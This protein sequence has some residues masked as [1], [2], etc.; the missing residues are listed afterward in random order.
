MRIEPLLDRIV[1]DG[2]LPDFGRGAVRISMLKEYAQL[3]PHLKDVDAKMI[4]PA[5]EQT[6]PGEIPCV[7]L[8][9]DASLLVMKSPA[10]ETFDRTETLPSG[11]AQPDAEGSFGLPAGSGSADHA[12][13]RGSPAQRAG[14]RAHL[15]IAALTVFRGKRRHAWSRP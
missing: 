13:P 12:C 10:S 9:I 5:K 6:A 14:W 3:Q 7:G 2:T 8:P 1:A 15:E 4:H 11:L